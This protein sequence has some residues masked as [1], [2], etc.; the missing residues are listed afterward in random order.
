MTSPGAAKPVSRAIDTL[1]RVTDGYFR[2]PT[3]GQVVLV[4][5]PNGKLT[6]IGALLGTSQVL[7]RANVV[8]P[9]DVLDVLFHRAAMGMLLWWSVDEVRHGKTKYLK[10]IGAM[11]LVAGVTRTILAE[12]ERALAKRETSGAGR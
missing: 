3:T 4:Q 8:S 12:R 7:R 1:A 5:K 10:T 6:A 2:D 9:G 11:T